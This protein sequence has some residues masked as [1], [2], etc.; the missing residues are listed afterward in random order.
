MIEIIEGAVGKYGIAFPVNVVQHSPR[1]VG[2]I[3]HIHIV[4]YD[5]KQFANI[6]CPLPQRP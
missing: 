3:L 4:I 1:S 6:I 2:K 5:D